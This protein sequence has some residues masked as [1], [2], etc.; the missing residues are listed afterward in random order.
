M[1]E[2][3]ISLS[4]GRFTP[5][6]VRLGYTVRRPLREGLAESLLTY[7]EIA[8]FSGAPRFRGRDDKCRAV[9]TYIEGSVPSELGHFEDAALAA[10]AGLLRRFHD[11]TA[12]F[13]AVGEAAAEVVCHNDFSPTN[14]VFRDGLPYAVIDF[15]TL[16]PGTRL[17]D[18]G[19]SAFTWLDIGNDDYS[20]AEQL[21]R[22]AVFADGYGLAACPAE[23]ILSHAVVRQN[24]LAA[25]ARAA[26]QS[27]IAEW[28][29]VAAEWTARHMASK[30]MP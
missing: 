5:G 1:D 24:A 20:G 22:L 29:A 15:D 14:A 30:S 10:A 16:A 9:L 25:K 7:L 12:G 13:P 18:L 3:E 11:A 6:V 4:G 27:D 2:E 23:A 26:G 8:G 21:R 28:A 19:Y 17:W